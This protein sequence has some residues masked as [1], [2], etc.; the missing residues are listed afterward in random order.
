M[1]NEAVATV[2]ICSLSLYGKRAHAKLALTA[3]AKTTAFDEVVSFHACPS[4]YDS[5]KLNRRQAAIVRSRPFY[6]AAFM[7]YIR[8]E[9]T[10]LRRAATSTYCRYDIS[11]SLYLAD[12]STCRELFLWWA[13]F[14]S[15]FSLGGAGY[16]VL[17]RSV[18]GIGKK[19][20]Q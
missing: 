5:L 20:T 9:N 8:S 14:V 18:I 1:G 4:R 6:N 12:F 19:S 10:Q 11:L 2:M 13:W 17:R 3:V 7:S 16:R 15:S